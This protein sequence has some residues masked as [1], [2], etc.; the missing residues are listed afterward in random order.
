MGTSFEQWDEM[1]H[2]CADIRKVIHRGLEKKKRK[3]EVR[4]L[5]EHDGTR[6][7]WYEVMMLGLVSPTTHNP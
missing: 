2:R 5:R 1:P 3:Q 6:I 4:I 7:M